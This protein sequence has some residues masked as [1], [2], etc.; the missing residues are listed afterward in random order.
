M[1]SLSERRETTN[2]IHTVG[3]Y[4]SR[5]VKLTYRDGKEICGCLGMREVA[6]WDD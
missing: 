1:I 3:V 6:R 4:D 5:K 2:I